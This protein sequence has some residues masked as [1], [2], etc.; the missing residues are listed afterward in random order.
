[1]ATTTSPTEHAQ[2]MAW[3]IQLININAI[4]NRQLARMVMEATKL[5]NR[6]RH[7][8]FA[9]V[10]NSVNKWALKALA[11]SAVMGHKF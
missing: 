9:N 6:E 8:H 7:S 11:G 10:R 2:L 5:K 1:M 3:R 4:D